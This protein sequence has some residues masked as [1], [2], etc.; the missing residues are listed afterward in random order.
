MPCLL[1]SFVKHVNKITSLTKLAFG[2][3]SPFIIH[4]AFV[5]EKLKHFLQEK[6]VEA[7]KQKGRK[8]EKT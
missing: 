8:E 6:A 4:P 5:V 2:E 7:T 3:I 1:W